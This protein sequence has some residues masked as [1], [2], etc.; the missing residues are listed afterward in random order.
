MSTFPSTITCLENKYIYAVVSN[1]IYL[2]MWCN[3]K[4][5]GNGDI[6]FIRQEK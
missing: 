2:L 3:H 1:I 5:S 6:F 4:N